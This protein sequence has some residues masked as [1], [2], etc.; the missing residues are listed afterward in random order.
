LKENGID[1]LEC[2][3]P[4]ELGLSW[5][6]RDKRLLSMHQALKG[7]YN[8][9]LVAEMNHKN[10]PLAYI[11]S[12]IY[13]KPLIFDPFISLFDS[14]V[15]DRKRVK[16]N[17][18]AALKCFL[19]DKISLKL[20]DLVITDTYQHLCYFRDR[21]GIFEDRI[22]VLYVGSDD[23][24]FNLD[25]SNAIPSEGFTVFFY[26]TFVPLHGIEYIVNA[27]YLL[28]KEDIHFKILGNGQTYQEIQDLANKFQPLNIT[29][30]PPVSLKELPHY[31]KNSS[32]SLGIFGNTPKTQRVIPTKVYNSMVMGKPVISGDTPAIREIFTDRENIMLCKCA[33]DEN[34]AETIMELNESQELRQ[35]IARN[36]YKLVKERFTQKAIGQR[37]VE[38]LKQFYREN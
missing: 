14:N 2:N 23:T 35:R 33:N 20:A 31:I 36:G 38:I 1:V 12:K 21:F 8:I 17:S 3:V 5:W 6:K 32:V 26:G 13:K 24:I 10:I 15:I 7:S 34:L 4:Y 37:L 30:L 9:L 19:W 16:A 28:R 29:F 11:L 22:S 18:F 25:H 27:A